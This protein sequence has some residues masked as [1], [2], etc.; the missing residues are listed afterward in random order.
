MMITRWTCYAG[1]LTLAACAGVPADHTIAVT[2]ANVLGVVALQSQRVVDHGNSV[3]TLQGLSADG[4]QVGSVQLTIG[5]IPDIADWAIVPS[6]VGSEILVTVAGQTWRTVT[7]ETRR[8]HLEGAALG[9]KTS[10]EFLQLG[11]VT[12]A[13]DREANI[14][15]E[16]KASDATAGEA[17]YLERTESCPQ[18][19]LTNAASALECCTTYWTT[20]SSL[21]TMHIQPSNAKNPNAIIERD[22]GFRPCS[23]LVNND[24]EVCGGSNCSYG[25]LGFEVASI[26]SPPAG[27][28]Y[29]NIS[30]LETIL[31]RIAFYSCSGVFTATE[32]SSTFSTVVG[33]G[34]P[35]AG[36]CGDQSGICCGSNTGCTGYK[37]C[38]MCGGDA[39]A[40]VGRWDY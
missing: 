19:V 7:L 35:G 25:P 8:F 28:P 24:P 9:D 23:I 33:D 2:Q 20:N 26:T 10:T 40:A 31:D 37:Q 16:P 12:A 1:L 3:Y 4:E 27:Y 17:A 13:L 30:S 34:A 6:D 11:A 32:Q 22:G 15:V 5:A 38:G 18:D 14:Q 36:C 29:G 39:P 21:Q